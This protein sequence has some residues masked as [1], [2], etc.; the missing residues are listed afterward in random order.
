[1]SKFAPLRQS[2]CLK[3]PKLQTFVWKQEQTKVYWRP[4]AAP[5]DHKISNSACSKNKNSKNFIRWPGNKWRIVRTTTTSATWSTPRS[6]CLTPGKKRV[7][8]SWI[9]RR[10]DKA[11]TFRTAL[12]A[13]TQAQR[14]HLYTQ[15]VGGEKVVVVSVS[16]STTFHIQRWLSPP[17]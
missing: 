7:V 6:W 13:H 4:G 8:F 16:F 14:L 11:K 9:W 3:A 1:M 17:S 2:T 5:K 12:H 10:I 15:G